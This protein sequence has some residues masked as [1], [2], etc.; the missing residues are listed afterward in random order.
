MKRIIILG[1]VVIV[2]LA[3]TMNK[4]FSN[5]EEAETKIFVRDQNK[6]TVVEIAIPT[7]YSFE[8]S[9]EYNGTFQAFRQ[10]NV[11][12]EIGGK[13]IEIAAK[14]G[15]YISKGSPIAKLD[16]ELVLL[17]IDALELNLEQLEIDQKRLSELEKNNVVS[18]SELEKVELGIKTTRNQLKQLQKQ[19]KSTQISAPYSGIVT[20]LMIELGSVIGPGTPVAELLD[21]QQ[22]KFNFQVPEKEISKFSVGQKYDVVCEVFPQ[23]NFTGNVNLVSAKADA[24]HNYKV[25]LTVQNTKENQ[26]KAG[27]YG[28]VRIAQKNSKEEALCIP[29]K[30]L[31]G[32]IEKPEV[33]R[34]KSGLVEKVAFIAGKN[35]SEQI[36]I[37]SGINATDTIVTKGQ[38]NLQIDSK[39]AI[40]K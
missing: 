4:L 18:K 6:A 17:Q 34:V 10:N 8:E 24:T 25:Q 39:I 12:S 22:L 1:L 20:K 15:E 9:N 40:K 7:L 19:L 33:F 16:Q 30:A 14:E 21:I 37:I 31:I 11:G 38:I 3:L 29:R 32:S 2:L 26:I 35:N 36:E 28:F 27:M 23:N 13:I 5:K